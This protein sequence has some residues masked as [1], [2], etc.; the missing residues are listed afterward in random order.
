MS[1][2]RFSR[3]ELADMH[4]KHITEGQLKEH[5]QA[6]ETTLHELGADRFDLILPETHML[7]LVVQTDEHILGVIYGHYEHVERSQKG[8][9][10]LV[11]TDRRV[12]LIDR[13]LLFVHCEEISYDIISAVTYSRVMQ[14]HT[15]TLH[16]RIGDI[17]IHTFNQKCVRNFTEAIEQRIFS[18]PSPQI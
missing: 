14:G 10:A 4:R 2:M 13:K 17:H 15:V 7:P 11:A 8:R 1:L 16:T 12:L 6:I 18:R 5:G 9:G 3:E